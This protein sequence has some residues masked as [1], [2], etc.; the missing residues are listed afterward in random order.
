MPPIVS[1]VGTTKAGK[2]SLI[3]RLILEFKRRNIKIGVIK[4]DVHG[5][6]IDKPG[7][8]T[9]RFGQAGADNVMIVGPDKMALIARHC[10][11][12][13]LDEYL[14]YHQDMDL[15]LTEGFRSDNKP[16][17]EVFRKENKEYLLCGEEELVAVV[18]DDELPVLIS[19]PIYRFNEIDK[20]ADLIEK[21]F[22]IN[23]E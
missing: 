21:I 19:K 2:T 4:N 8:S 10:E 12:K 11:K 6:E 14:M 18:S 5:F 16:K 22:I 3:E 15:V 17:I 1:I 23:N 7:K 20:L 13:P 9:W